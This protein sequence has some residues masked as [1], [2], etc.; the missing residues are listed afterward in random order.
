MAIFSIRPMGLVAVTPAPAAV[1]SRVEEPQERRVPVANS[2]AGLSE[3]DTK[4]SDVLPQRN[5]VYAAGLLFAAG[6]G[7]GWLIGGARKSVVIAAVDGV[8]VF[9]AYYVVAQVIERIQ[10][11]FTPWIGRAKTDDGTTVAQP[12]AKATRENKVAEARKAAVDPKKTKTEVEAAGVAA[13]KAQRI[14]DQIRVNLTLVLW[15]S[16]SVLAMIASAYFGLHLLKAVG[17]P[18]TG[19]PD[20]LMDILITGLAIGGGTKPLHDLI[21]NFTEAKTEKQDPVETK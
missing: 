1:S 12:K 10:E 17:I 11:P 20:T 6:L 13:A 21:S 9:A 19:F 18:V 8:S 14:V 7:L 2:G 16:S 15:A 4:D 3:T 5:Y